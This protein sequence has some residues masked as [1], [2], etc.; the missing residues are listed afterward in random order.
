MLEKIWEYRNKQLKNEDI[1]ALSKKLGLSFVMTVILMNR[2]LIS[3]DE[4]GAYKK[5]SLEEIHSPFLFPDME[6]ATARI[7]AAI[8]KKEKIVIYGDYDVDGITSTSILYL[9]LKS[10]GADISYYIP[11]R[12]TEGYGINIMAVNRLAKSGVRLMI[13]VDCGITSVGEVEFAKTQGMDVII[14]DH[15]TPK[16]DIPKAVAVLNPKVTDCGY[17]FLHLA[18]VGV[19]FKLVLGL[20]KKLC[21]NTRDVFFKY[22]D[23]ASLGTIADS[24]LLLGENRVIADKGISALQNT[25]NSGIKALIKVSGIEDRTIASTSVA[26]ALAPRLNVSG[27]LENASLSVELLTSDNFGE[28]LKIA[29]YLTELNYKRQQIEQE[30]YQDALSMIEDYP[31]DNIVYVLKGQNWHHGVCGIVASK[32]CE[33]LYRPVI[34]ISCENGVGKASCRS[35]EEFNLFDALT[36]SEELLTTFGGHAQAA[37]LTICEENSCEFTKRINKYAKAHIGE[38]KLMPK[39]KIDCDLEPTSLTLSA[40]KTLMALE[41][42][43]IGNENPTFSA[44]R[45]KVVAISSMGADKKHLRM[46]LSG[47]NSIFNAVGFSMADFCN[48]I[49]VG[50]YVDIAF[51]MGVN[52]YQGTESLQLILK[53]IK[54]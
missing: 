22:V 15:H 11:D 10:Q 41:P 23:L 3:E 38:V 21:M 18:G 36:D 27:R 54:K 51:N 28:A 31:K 5:K 7:I 33:K 32:L 14:T 46:R 40:A 20:C 13:S 53:D 52:T 26:Y 25:N 35:I 19:A 8:E 37:G 42:F 48:E 16:E 45:L 24:V 34:L 39:I 29:E 9:F 30:I 43:G 6:K 47:G 4:I 17:P 12:F 1:Y 50:D 44:R 49:A 2:G